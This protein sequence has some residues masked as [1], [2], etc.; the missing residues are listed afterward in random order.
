MVNCIFDG[1]TNESFL[2]AQESRRSSRL[3]GSTASTLA[4]GLNW[5]ANKKAKPRWERH[6]LAGCIQEVLF[7]EQAEAIR[8][9]ARALAEIHPRRAGRDNAARELLGMLQS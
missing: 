8:E 9:K 1:R 2:T 3:D 5:W 4:T 6:E 7:R